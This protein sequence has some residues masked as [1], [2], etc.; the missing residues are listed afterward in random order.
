M[1]T[2][3]NAHG[4]RHSHLRRKRRTIKSAPNLCFALTQLITFFNSPSQRMCLK[5]ESQ[6]RLLSHPANKVWGL[7]A[8][9]EGPLRCKLRTI[10]SAEDL[11]FTLTKFLTFSDFSWQMVVS[12]NGFPTQTT[13]T[14]LI[15]Y[16][17]R[18]PGDSKGLGEYVIQHS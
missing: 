11:S 7:S 4:T 2:Y 9:Q 8:G 17:W 6:F 3:F 13:I 1:G 14:N 5:M 15:R 10:K 18:F 16:P 12:Q